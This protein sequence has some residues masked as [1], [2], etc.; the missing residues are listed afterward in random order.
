MAE[1]ELLQ[2]ILMEL[3]TLNQRV[4]RLEERMDRLEKRMD[5]LEERMDRLEERMNRLEET[6]QKNHQQLERFYVEQQ[7]FNTRIFK[8][9]DKLDIRYE[10]QHAILEDYGERIR[11]LEQRPMSGVAEDVTK[12]R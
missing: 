7:E 8:R 12:W 3:K 1:K 9:L 6:E 2:M 5:R 10:Q 11:R 4:G